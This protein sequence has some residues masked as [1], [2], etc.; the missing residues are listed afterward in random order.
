VRLIVYTSDYLANDNSIELDL[1][2]ITQAAKKRNPSLGITG[3]L[4]YHQGKFLQL[5]EGEPDNIDQIMQHINTDKRHN[6]IQLYIDQNVESRCLADWNMDSL[7]LSKE[8]PLDSREMALLTDVYKQ[9]LIVNTD[10]LLHFYKAMLKTRAL[11]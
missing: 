8:T 9:N 5:L 6:N 10:A 2:D 11:F 4:F 1:E 7:N 3:V